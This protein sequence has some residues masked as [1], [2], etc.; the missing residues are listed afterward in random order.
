[1]PLN[2]KSM[3]SDA[4]FDIKVNTNFYLMIK[5]TTLYVFQSEKDSKIITES[6]KN[7][8]EKQYN[9]LSPYEKAVYTL[10]LLISEMERVATITELIDDNSILQPGDEGYIEPSEDSV[11]P[12]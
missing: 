6:L 12:Y 11:K 5:E 2:I 7:I 10:S 8:K 3:K 9:E 1:M 4:T